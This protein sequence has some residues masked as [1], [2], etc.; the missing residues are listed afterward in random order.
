VSRQDPHFEEKA[1]VL[2]L[3]RQGGVTSLSH[4]SCR[5]RAACRAAIP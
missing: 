3:R 2:L 4:Q 1:L 5:S